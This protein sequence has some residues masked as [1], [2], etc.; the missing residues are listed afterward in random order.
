[1]FTKR[2]EDYRRSGN[3]DSYNFHN[4]LGPHDKEGNVTTMDMKRVWIFCGLPFGH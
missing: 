3:N 2:F 4:F 1:M